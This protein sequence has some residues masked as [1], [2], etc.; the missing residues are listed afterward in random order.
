MLLTPEPRK[1]HT[2]T[3]ATFCCSHRPTWHRVAETMGHGP[4]RWVILEGSYL[5]PSPQECLAS[6]RGAQFRVKEKLEL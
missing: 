4:G 6:E 5:S 3:S 2:P 1:C